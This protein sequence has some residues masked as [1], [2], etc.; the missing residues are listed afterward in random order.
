MALPEARD[1]TR[2]AAGAGGG[3]EAR[4]LSV[5]ELAG[6]AVGG[7]IGSGW[8]FASLE[9]RHRGLAALWDWGLCGA[10]MVVLAAVMVEL[11][12]ARPK[13]GGLIFLPLQSS[14][15][16]VATVMAAGL[17]IFYLT[18]GVSESLA[19]TKVFALSFP[20]LLHSPGKE[21]SGWGLACATALLAVI[22]AVNLL[23]PRP[24]V[25]IVL[26]LAVWKVLALVLVV[27]ALFRAGE[28]HRAELYPAAHDPGPGDGGALPAL[29]SSSM[30]FAYIGFQGP[31]DFAGNVKREGIGEA[32]RLRRAVYGTLA[33]A[34]ALY[35]AAQVA[36]LGHPELSGYPAGDPHVLTGIVDRVGWPGYVL[37]ADAVVAPLGTGL[38]YAH[39]LTREVDTLAKAHLTH[40]G[41]QTAS[42]RSLTVRGRP[43]EVYWKV[44]LVNFVLGSVILLAVRGTWETITSVNGILTLVVYAMPGVV[45]VALGPACSRRREAVRGILA[46]TG[47]L[48]IALVLYWAESS[49]LWY[50][51]A[52]L[53]AGFLL[54][55][56]LP[57]LARTGLPLVGRGAYDAKEQLTLLRQWRT[58]PAAGAA[59]L[60]LGYLAALTALHSLTQQ[61]PSDAR[62]GTSLFVLVLAAAVFE[63]LV[64]LSRRHRRPEPAPEPGPADPVSR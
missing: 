27:V 58:N 38:V 5:H 4:R 45:L 18:N 9:S 1:G 2:Q 42:G 23:P 47:F 26:G 22:A 41:L 49:R 33:G 16:L 17:W 54:L 28:Y 30:L 6:L 19:T 8:L 24:F 46:R 60:L 64:R 56:G 59:V 62:A 21:L 31:L 51:M 10:M 35:F 39:A 14:G 3:D 25:R 57:A 34:T 12:T 15:T 63:G 36:L 48:T 37:L 44:L 11:G 50:G 32:A 13:T 55:L 29:V 61:W 43:Y 52:A 40:R 53:M 7:M 20:G